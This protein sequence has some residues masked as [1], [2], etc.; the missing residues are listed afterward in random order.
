MTRI[1]DKP[2]FSWRGVLLDT[3]RHYLAKEA[4]L[5]NLVRLDT[6]ITRCLYEVITLFI[7]N[8]FN[9]AICDIK[10]NMTIPAYLTVW[11]IHNLIPALAV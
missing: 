8:T 4:I 3:S 9:I 1:E 10:S 6:L 5:Q 7:I 2:R 11:Y